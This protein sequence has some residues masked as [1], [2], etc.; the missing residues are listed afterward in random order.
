MMNDEMKR[1][2]ERFQIYGC[3]RSSSKP[4]VSGLLK[5]FTIKNELLIEKGSYYSRD[6]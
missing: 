2:L 6:P 4:I 5:V 3:Y 1:N